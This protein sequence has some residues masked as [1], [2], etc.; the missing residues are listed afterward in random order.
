MQLSVNPKNPV[1]APRTR[2]G[3]HASWIR[4]G[5]GNWVTAPFDDLNAGEGKDANGIIVLGGLGSQR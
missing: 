4:N 2:C 3:I 1:V 5:R